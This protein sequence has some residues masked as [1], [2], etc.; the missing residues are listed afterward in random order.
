MEWSIIGLNFLYAALGVVLMYVSYRTIDKLT[1][2][3]NFAEELRKGNVAVAIFI[4]AIFVSI[5]LIIGG[6]LN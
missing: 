6:A 5:A 3:V 4:A 1:P 2:E